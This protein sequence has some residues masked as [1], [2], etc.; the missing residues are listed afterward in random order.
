MME[1]SIKDRRGL[2]YRLLNMGWFLPFLLTV[3]SGFGVMMLYAV[4]MGDLSRWGYGHMFHFFVGFLV[5]F[6]IAMIDLRF[7]YRWSYELFFVSLFFLILVEFVGSSRMGAQRWLGLGGFIFQ[8]SEL[9]KITLILVLARFF[10]SGVAERK[11]EWLSIVM[12]LCMMMVPV[13]FILRQ[14]DLGTGLVLMLTGFSILFLSG[15]PWRKLS[16]LVGAGLLSVPLMWFYVLHAYQKKRVLTFLGIDSDVTGDMYHITQSKIALGSGGLWGQGFLEGS[17]SNLSFLPEKQTDFIFTVIAEQ[18]G[19]VGVLVVLGLYGVVV[20]YGL[21]VSMNS[22]NGFGKLVAS[23][24]SMTFGFY[25]VVN[26]GMVSGMLPVVGIP[27]PLIS[28]GGTSMVVMMALMG[29]V[30]NVLI[31][32]RLSR[33]EGMGWVR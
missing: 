8:P 10:V 13:V 12:S 7:L 9:L 21:W 5:M 15:I 3:L 26:V 18:F 17:Q 19:F 1:V 14:P 31:E 2:N 20:V 27:L 30:M 6:V 29:L 33:R 4:A 23:G 28:R 16:V 11:R 32:N 25:V 24:A 22:R